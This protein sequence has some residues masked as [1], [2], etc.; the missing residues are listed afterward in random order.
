LEKFYC[1]ARPGKNQELYCKNTLTNLRAAINRKLADLKRNVDIVKDRDFKTSNGVLNGLLKERKRHGTLKSTQHV[2]LMD[3]SDLEK[4]STY[5]KDATVNP[6]I[7]RQCVYFQLSLHFMSRGQ[8]FH[9]QLKLDSIQFHTDNTGEYVTLK[10]EMQPHDPPGG[11]AERNADKRMYATGAAGCPVKMLKLLIRKTD[12][13][14]SSLFNRYTKEA[15]SLPKS[16]SEW[17][18][19]APLSKRTFSNFMKDISKAAGLSRHYTGHCLRTTAIQHLNDEGYEA[20]DIRYMSDHKNEKSLRW[21]NR[22]ISS[23]QKKNLSS[24]LSKIIDPTISTSKPAS[25]SSDFESPQSEMRP[26]TS[27]T[28]LQQH[29]FPSSFK[30]TDM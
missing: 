13:S 12:D 15:V 21:Y 11:I 24:A 20:Y 18:L 29:N 26:A 23:T 25:Q 3:K 28:H 10:H 22:E 16:S 17:Y 27:E 2:E 6:I 14:A 7:L 19:D 9:H 4:I 1:E 5:F 8:E 30:L